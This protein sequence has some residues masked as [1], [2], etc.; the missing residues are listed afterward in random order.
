MRNLTTRYLPL[1]CPTLLTKQRKPVLTRL[2]TPHLHLLHMRRLYLL[3][4]ADHLISITTGFGAEKL[5][6]F[7]CF[8]LQILL[9]DKSHGLVCLSVVVVVLRCFVVFLRPAHKYSVFFYFEAVQVLKSGERTE[10]VVDLVLFVQV[11]VEGG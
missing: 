11:Y 2:L 10:Q 1:A 8:A 4:S 7:V 6:I 5:I 3:Q 9:P